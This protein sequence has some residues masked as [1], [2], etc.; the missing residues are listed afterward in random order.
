LLMHTPMSPE[1]RPE[2]AP[3]T[4]LATRMPTVCAQPGPGVDAASRRDL[5][6]GCDLLD[7]LSGGLNRDLEKGN[8]TVDRIE[9]RVFDLVPD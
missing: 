1:I 2:F 4:P 9:V 7:T 3:D 6:L 8:F 5:R